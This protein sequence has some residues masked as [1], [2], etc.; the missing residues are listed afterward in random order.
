MPILVKVKAILNFISNYV[1]NASNFSK[2]EPSIAD[3]TAPILSL[4][5]VEISL[6]KKII[7]NIIIK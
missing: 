5:P 3:L 2:K 4:I 7:L 6:K 1:S